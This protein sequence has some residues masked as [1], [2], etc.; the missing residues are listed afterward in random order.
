MKEHSLP[1]APVPLATPS[2]PKSPLPKGAT[3]THVHM[4]LGPDDAPR[5]D[6]RLEDPAPGSTQDWIDRLT[7]TMAAVGFDRA[8]LVHSIV[9]GERPD[10]L[11]TL[12]E[13]LPADRFRG[14]GILDPALT[15]ESLKTLVRAG[16]RGLRLNLR[17][18]GTATLDD[19]VRL[20][21]LLAGYGVHLQVLLGGADAL[22]TVAETLASIPAEVVLDHFAGTNGKGLLDPV[23]VRLL[24]RGRLTVKLTAAYRS[25]PPPYA[26]A[27]RLV[28]KLSAVRP[29]R[30]VFGTDWPYVLFDGQPVDAGGLVD[31]V[32]ET[33]K[34]AETLRLIFV[35]TPAR[36]YGFDG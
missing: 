20:A 27:C 32:A 12:L 7:G 18:R 22:P 19:A 10:A 29:D 13:R 23:L 17:H 14:V 28:A 16:V 8:V 3:D 15:A 11:L 5:S 1:V 25:Q 21:P 33:V 2:A 9:Y 24:E 34:D 31:L 30:L 26:D 35:E 6:A 4:F 36:L